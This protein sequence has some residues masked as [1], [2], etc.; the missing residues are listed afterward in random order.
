MTQFNQ[1]LGVLK[2]VFKFAHSRS[3]FGRKECGQ[4]IGRCCF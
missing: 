3:F 4:I 1:K 2:V